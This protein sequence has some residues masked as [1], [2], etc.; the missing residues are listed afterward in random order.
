MAAT[1]DTPRAKTYSQFIASLALVYL[2]YAVITSTIALKR[3]GSQEIA[4]VGQ[5][6][7]GRSPWMTLCYNLPQ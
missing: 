3:F 1:A 6:D 4:V 7:V 2:N 5:M